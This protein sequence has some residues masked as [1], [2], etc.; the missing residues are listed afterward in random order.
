M[1]T[2]LGRR[3]WLLGVL[4]MIAAALVPLR[5]HAQT[6]VSTLLGTWNAAAGGTVSQVVSAGVPGA[7]T[8]HIKAPC[9]PTPCDWGTRP[10]T[11]YAPSPA[12][13][14]GKIGSATYNQGFVSRTVIVTAQDAVAPFL[15][16]DVLSKFAPGD[17]RSNYATT[18]TLH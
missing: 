8:I 10:L 13:H 12:I 6:A 17:A 5:A 1:K 11:I 7:Y 3:L 16:V 4:A 9:A 2:R 14:V 15:R 18:Q